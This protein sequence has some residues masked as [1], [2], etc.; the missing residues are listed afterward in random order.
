[1][2]LPGKPADLREALVSEPVSVPDD[3][4]ILVLDGLQ[5]LPSLA[6]FTLF[7]EAP[8]CHRGVPA[9]RRVPELHS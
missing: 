2:S 6:A 4:K 7:Q 1:M 3:P 8:G 9:N 5:G